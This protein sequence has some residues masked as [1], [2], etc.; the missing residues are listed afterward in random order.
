M[1]KRGG[2]GSWSFHTCPPNPPPVILFSLQDHA[3]SSLVLLPCI[4]EMGL[5][6]AAYIVIGEMI[7]AV[8]V[9]DLFY[10]EVL[11][12]LVITFKSIIKQMNV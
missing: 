11:Q 1:V 2:G 8:F 6:S 10:I 9:P 5:K 12:L 3:T 7:A 4:S